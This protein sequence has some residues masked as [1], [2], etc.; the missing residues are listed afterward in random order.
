MN[1][2]ANSY[3]AIHEME[4]GLAAMEDALNNHS[5]H[6]DASFMLGIE[7]GEQVYDLLSVA[8]E[9]LKAAIIYAQNGILC[10]VCLSISNPGSENCCNCGIPFEE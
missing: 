6:A 2:P 3:R 1:T 4:A 7:G 8:I 5:L 9:D 10:P